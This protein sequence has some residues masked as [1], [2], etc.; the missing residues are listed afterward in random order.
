MG[1]SRSGRELGRKLD[2][3]AEDFED[4]PLAAVKDG[5]QIVKSSVTRL[6]PGRLRNA[7]KRG[8]KLGV[9]YNLGTYGGE[10]K[11]LVFVTGPFHLIER[12]TKP[13]RIPA[14]VGQKTRQNRAVRSSRGRLYGP[15][16]GGEKASTRP[17]V[18][19]GKVRAF[20]FHPGTRGKRPWQ[21][22]VAA[23]LPKVRNVISTRSATTLRRIF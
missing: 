18:F 12:D 20:A 2:R 3:L 14:L 1:S 23:A 19:A 8:S 9:R 15:A 22:G 21:R 6:A 13:H 17:I 4:L 11:S 10:A 5:S 16:F 7:S